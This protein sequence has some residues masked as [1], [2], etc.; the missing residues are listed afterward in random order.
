MTVAELI[1]TLS[2]MPQD[3]RVFEDNHTEFRE[4]LPENV[5]V[6]DGCITDEG[7]EV[8]ETCVILNAWG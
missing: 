7:E 6:A 8:E 5:T 4:V 3:A 1:A 2:K